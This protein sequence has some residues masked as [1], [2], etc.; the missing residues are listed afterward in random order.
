MLGRLP[1]QFFLFS[2]TDFCAAATNFGSDNVT[3]FSRSV[4]TD[5]IQTLASSEKST[6]KHEVD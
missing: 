2:L 3:V 5:H 6:E 4:E 1:R